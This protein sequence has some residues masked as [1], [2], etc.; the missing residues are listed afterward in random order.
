MNTEYK[1]YCKNNFDGTVYKLKEYISLS[2]K[3]TLVT[4]RVREVLDTICMMYIVKMEYGSPEAKEV[5]K[6][7]KILI[8][9]VVTALKK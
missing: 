8:E 9:G 3:E 2:E 4:E 1:Q 5:K 7:S 6:R